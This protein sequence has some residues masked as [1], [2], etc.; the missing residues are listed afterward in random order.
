[1]ATATAPLDTSWSWKPVSWPLIHEMT[2]MS[3]WPSRHSC[4]KPRRSASM[5]TRSRHAPGAAAIS[6]T[7]RRSSARSRSWSNPSSGRGGRGRNGTSRKA[8]DACVN[9]FSESVQ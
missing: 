4:S 3:T 2:Q 6:A 5:R 1:M 8:M 7:T 9:R